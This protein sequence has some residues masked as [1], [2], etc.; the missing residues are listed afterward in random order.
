MSETFGAQ[1]KVALTPRA[2]RRSSVRRLPRGV[3]IAAVIPIGLIALPIIYVVIRSADA[4]WAGIAAELFRDRTL[5]LFW[6][7]S[8]LTFSVTGLSLLIGFAGAWCT[9]RSDLPLAGLWR[10]LL[11]LP[12]AMP[13]FVASFAWKSIG[14]TFQGLAGAVLILTLESFPLVFLPV[15]AALRSMDA[16]PDEVSRSLGRGPIATFLRVIAPRALPAAGG[17]ALLVAAHMLSE[18]GA[19]SLLRVQTLTTAIFQQYELEFDNASGAVLSA[20]LMLLCLPVAFGEIH[21]RGVERRDKVGRSAMRSRRPARLGRWTP[22]VIAFFLAL[23]SLSLGVPFG[24]LAYWLMRGVSVGRGL[25]AI[26]PALWGSISL[27]IPG[28]FATTLVALPLVLLALRG[29][30]RMARLAERLPYIVHGLPGLVVALS[31]VYA[32]IR[33]TPAIYQTRIVLFAAYAIL[34]MPLAQSALRASAELVSPEM[35]DVART[36]GRG[37]LAAF[38]SVTLPALMPG[39]GAALALVALELMRELT[40]TLILAPTGVA[41]LATEVWSLTSDG[42]Y[43]AAAPF[44]AAL[45]LISG[46]PVYVFTLRTLRPSSGRRSPKAQGGRSRTTGRHSI[47]SI[48]EHA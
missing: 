31:L 22:F 43:A 20:M 23:A 47:A 28:T 15:A 41:T 12:L 36:L 34:F 29:G 7:T 42:A 26:G 24:R 27:A 38:V 1:A 19:L 48:D 39:F 17:G 18:F 44:A 32:A 8:V 13:A 33:L 40:A 16:G 9:E 25:D 35:E 3:A 30:G 21:L 45:V 4:G 5:M 37:S 10:V 14:P 2:A 11:A 6:N 46:L